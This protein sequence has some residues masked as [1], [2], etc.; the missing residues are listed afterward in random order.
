MSTMIGIGY[1]AHDGTDLFDHLK[2]LANKYDY[3]L[4][5]GLNHAEA[6]MRSGAE[7]AQRHLGW[8]HVVLLQSPR[9]HE[10]ALAFGIE[11]E[12]TDHLT[13]GKSPRFFQFLKEVHVAFANK[14]TTL[15]IF[16][17]SDWDPKD[18][19]RHAS[20]SMDK[21]ISLLS[22]PGSW[23]IVFMIPETGHLQIS[24]EFPFLFDVKLN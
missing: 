2:A 18:W 3:G 22:E 17:S 1:S 14:C 24:S 11:Q 8:Q 13:K 6:D 9:N 21:L 4:L 12:F 19:V 23:G 16:F 10:V 7:V 20:G 15:S 5:N